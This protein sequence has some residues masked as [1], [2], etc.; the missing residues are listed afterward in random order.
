MD[1]V[2]ERRGSGPPL[3]LLH[4]IGSRWQ[5]FAPVL[6]LLARG[7][8]VWALDLPGFGASPA[9]R[10]PIASASVSAP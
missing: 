10:P 5:A 1:L 6:D 3:V 4:G 8:D 2:F 7:F 9:P